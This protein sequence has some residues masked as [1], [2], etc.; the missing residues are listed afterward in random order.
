MSTESEESSGLIEFLAWVETHK[1]K[2]IVG[3]IGA[4]VVGGAVYVSQWKADHS[5]QS[6]GTALFDVQV[7]EGETEDAD[8]PS[9]DEYLSVEKA[10]PGTSAAER[11]LLL[12][13]RGHF[14]AGDYDQAKTTF[15][16]FQAEYA[17]SP[18]VATAL[19][20]VA[21]SLD[22]AGKLNEAKSGYQAVL[23]RFP[24]TPVAA[25]AKLATANIHESEGEVAEALAL[26]DELNRPGV[27][28]S[29]SS[30]ALTRRE[31]LLDKN[32]ELRP[33]PE[34]V[35][36][37]VAPTTLMPAENVTTETT[38]VEAAEDSSQSDSAEEAT[39]N[40]PTNE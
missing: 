24:N 11:A 25:Q 3:G 12:A 40:S 7:K 16:R 23:S 33:E 31:K 36:S 18:Y 14:M 4:I 21:A 34:A 6:A 19:Y 10:H 38:V 1:Q 35:T 30:R 17:S 15:E 5:E 22:A 37:S 32:P 29:Y 28:A 27:P 13:A 9:P 8:K 26:Y 20:G 39:E 2:L